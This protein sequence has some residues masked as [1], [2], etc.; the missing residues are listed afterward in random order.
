MTLSQK[1]FSSKHRTD[2]PL[3][4]I[5]GSVITSPKHTGCQSLSNYGVNIVKLKLFCFVQQILTAFLEFLSLKVA[6]PEHIL[7]NIFPLNY[8]FQL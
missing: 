8:I 7:K 6:L 2:Q 4:K 5:L 1:A 3:S